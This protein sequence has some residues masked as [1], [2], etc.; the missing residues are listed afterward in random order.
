MSSILIGLTTLAAA[1]LTTAIAV[2]DHRLA[3]FRRLG[4]F[5]RCLDTCDGASI[6]LDETGYPRLVASHRGCELQAELIPDTMTM[7]RLPQL[8]LSV[9]HMV[10]APGRAG[11]ALLNRPSG[12][13]Y[14]SMTNRFG[15]PLDIPLGMPHEILARGAG[16]LSQALLDRGAA[17]LGRIFADPRV[18]E[19]AVTDRGVR[20]IIQNA[21]GRYGEHLLLRQAAFDNPVVAPDLLLT[22]VGHID[23][24]HSALREEMREEAA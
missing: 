12:N 5:D 13:D 22:V 4:L 16:N 14:F 23:S 21:Q 10:A 1:G 17:P 6:S 2:R 19:I 9:T 24:L 20:I 8:W 15:V 11:F 18:K 3:H 7:R